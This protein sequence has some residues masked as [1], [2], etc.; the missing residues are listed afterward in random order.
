M[1][2]GAIVRVKVC[3]ECGVE[4][5]CGDGPESDFSPRMRR[6]DGSVTRWHA[7]CKPC[8]VKYK[9]ARLEQSVVTREA[10]LARRR[11][12]HAER[13]AADPEY[14]RR[15]NDQA[16]AAHA[17]WLAKPGSREAALRSARESKRRSWERDPEGFR[18]LKRIDYALRRERAGLPVRRR[19]DGS[20]QTGD[21]RI[22]AAAFCRWLKVYRRGF[23]GTVEEMARELGIPAVRVRGVLDGQRLVA[24]RVVD[25]ALLSAVRV[26][27]VDGRL[28]VRFDDLY[29]DA[30]EN[31]ILTG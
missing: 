31:G 26:V 15:H 6:P 29:P 5:V 19:A 27:R 30:D 11:A 20:M 23:D 1:R 28:I 17:R 9:R 14:R 13:M 3:A 16:A 18:E 10:V 22:P 7:Y 2:D 4:K 25:R 21:R 8:S 12:R 24:S